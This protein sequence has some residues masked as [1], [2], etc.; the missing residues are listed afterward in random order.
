M[1][2]LVLKVVC[3]DIIAT[4][5]LSFSESDRTLNAK[6]RFSCTNGNGLIGVEEVKCLPSGRWSAP[7]PAC[8]NIVCPENITTMSKSHLKV[9]V[10]SFAAGGIAYFSCGRGNVLHGPNQAVCRETGEWSVD[11]TSAPERLPEGARRYVLRA[12]SLVAFRVGGKNPAE[13][14]FRVASRVQT[15]MMSRPASSSVYGIKTNFD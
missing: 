1:F 5:G 2:R 11:E 3:P 6:V 14:G 15:M 9:H 13:A 4:K 10:H 8:M 12:G 7:I